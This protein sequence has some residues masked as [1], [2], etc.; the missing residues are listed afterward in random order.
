MKKLI[1]FTIFLLLF[2]SRAEAMTLQ[3]QINNHVS[4]SIKKLNLESKK[5][6]FDA[7][8]FKYALK[9]KEVITA[10]INRDGVKD[11]IVVLDF[12]EETT[13]HP[14]TM[15]TEVVVFIAKKDQTFKLLGSY[16]YSVMANVKKDKNGRIYVHQYDYFDKDGHCCPSRLT[17]FNLHI[18]DGK[19][20][21]RKVN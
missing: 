14:T 11:R 3:Q 17:K 15:S 4:K 7:D 18:K 6:A 8:Y 9:A 21:S 10:D 19:L 13:C 5:D 20:M 2:I 16:F 12:C 1:L